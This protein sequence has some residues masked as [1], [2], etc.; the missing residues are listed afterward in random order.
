LAAAMAGEDIEDRVEQRHTWRVH[1]W[2][3]GRCDLNHTFAKHDLS[4]KRVH[5]TVKTAYTA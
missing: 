5:L 3:K 2:S 1:P 4:S